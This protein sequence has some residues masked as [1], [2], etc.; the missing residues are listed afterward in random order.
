MRAVLLALVLVL[1]GLQYR[2]LLAPG[3]LFSVQATQ[4]R[5]EHAQDAVDLLAERNDQL[6]AEVQD[7]RTGLAAVEDRAR[8]ELGMIRSGETFIRVIE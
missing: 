2:L 8:S 6:T 1:I 3:N 5:V 4:A 7:L